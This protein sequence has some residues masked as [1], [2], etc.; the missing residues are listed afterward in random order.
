[1]IPETYPGTTF[2]DEGVCNHCLQYENKPLLGEDDFLEK[3]KSK[4]GPI[5]DCILGISGGKDSSSAAYLAKQRFNLRTLAV[6]YDFPFLVDLAR[7]NIKKICDALDLALLVIKTKN[8]LE[9]KLLREHLISLSGTGT[10]WGQCMFCHYGIDAV[11][12]NVAKEKDIPFILSGITKYELWNPGSRTKFLLQRV[13]G[14]PF[15]ELFGFM[16]HQSKAYLK[17]IDQRKQFPIPGNSCFASYKRAS[18]PNDGPELIHVFEYLK[19]DARVIEET[20]KKEVGWTKPK[21]ATSWR[22]DCILEPLLDYTYKKEFGISTVGLYLSGL[23]RD[24]LIT[25]EEALKIQKQ[26]EDDQAL[27]ASVRHVFNFLQ[28]PHKYQDKFFRS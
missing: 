8:N 19:W 16:Y 21:K 24:G 17:L 18:L 28:I 4:Q 26:S 3:I 27:E 6:C 5:Y 14:L 11:L 15:K 23:I 2:N 1:L 9:Y 13:K 20:L 25:R 10:T 22:Y 12:Y 7:Q